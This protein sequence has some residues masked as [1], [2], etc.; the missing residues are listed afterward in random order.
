[1]APLPSEGIA[2]RTVLG[3]AI[4]SAAWI[5]LSDSALT[6]VVKDPDIFAKI[7]ILKGWLF[8]SVTSA[9]LYVTLRGQLRRQQGEA[10]ERQRAVRALVASEEQLA[11]ALKMAN[12]GHWE[13][14]V[15]KNLFTFNDHFYRVLRTTAEREGGY[16]MTPARYSE[17]FLPPEYASFVSEEVR[18][19]IG[20]A[21]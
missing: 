20:V 13:Y 17:R 8:V 10:S 5:L 9:L 12:A 11:S 4:F 16:T 19:A 7:S 21:N 3:Y 6:A 14:D 15:A 1:M 2:L 18:K